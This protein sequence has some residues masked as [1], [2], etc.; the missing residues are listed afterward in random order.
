[1]N[2]LHLSIVTPERIVYE[3]EVDSVSVMTQMGER[4]I[5]N[6]HI[7]LVATLQAGEL[8]FKKNGT[9]HYLV[10]ST[11]FLQVHP[12]NKVVIL[13]DSAERVE[14]LE[15]E[16]IEAA[17]ERAKALLEQKRHIDDVA[18]AD[19]SALLERELARYKVALKRKKYK[20]VGKI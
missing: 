6:Q 7:P 19:A 3:D 2:K 10:S 5:L 17:K 16:K 11:G 20:D 1:M 18:F 12:Q 15:L 13:A 14:E 4:T 9:E 8:R